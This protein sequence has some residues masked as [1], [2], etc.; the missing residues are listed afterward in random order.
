MG[1]K[2]ALLVYSDQ[3]PAALL[4]KAPILGRDA[5]SALVAATHP[6]WTGTGTS[7]ESLSDC[8]YPPDG[9]VYAG[10]F[11]GS[12]A[13]GE[14]IVEDI[15]PALPFEEPFWAGQHTVIPT[16]GRPAYPLPFHP[17]DLG[18]AALRDLLGFAIE[19][20][21]S[22]PP[23]ILGP[24]SAGR[25]LVRRVADQDDLRRKW[26]VITDD[27]TQLPAERREAGLE[28]LVSMIADRLSNAERTAVTS[29]SAD[30]P[31]PRLRPAPEARLPRRS[32]TLAICHSANPSMQPP[33]AQ[34]LGA[35][36]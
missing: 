33:H 23:A 28:N 21:R 2:T 26:L 16:P 31:P 7:T 10:S 9:I 34:A 24:P 4:R 30:A 14:G 19:G 6:G 15:G 8:V 13:P 17:L 3:H 29:P 18:E 1:A 35:R 32:A 27:G 20:T 36:S 5:A 11:P 25:G 22:R 12:M